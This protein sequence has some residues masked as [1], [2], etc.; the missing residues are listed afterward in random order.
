MWILI[1]SKQC[2]IELLSHDSY[3][4]HFFIHHYAYLKMLSSNGFDCNEIFPHRNLNTLQG[5]HFHWILISNISLMAMSLNLNSAYYYIFRSLSMVAHIIDI[6][7]SYFADILPIWTWSLN[8]LISQ[9]LTESV[10][11]A[12]A[13]NMLSLRVC[14]FYRLEIVN[15][16]VVAQVTKHPKPQNHLADY[17]TMLFFYHQRRLRLINCA[18]LFN[19][20]TFSDRGV[21]NTPDP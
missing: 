9:C 17:F 21:L 16:F 18:V 15:F 11:T 1:T 5:K 8:E 2:R 19:L 6:Q 13:N 3:R 10:E 14:G 12:M 4:L 7:R 20:M